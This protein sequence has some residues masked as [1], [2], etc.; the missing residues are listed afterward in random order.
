MKKSFTILSTLVLMFFFSSVVSAQPLFTEDFESGTAS[1]DWGVYRAGEENVIA[2][3]MATAPE[4][5]ANGGDYVGYVQDINGSYSG[6]AI[7]LAGA[8]SLQNYS[9]EGDVYCYVNHPGGSAYT[10]L[11]VYSDSSLGTYIKLAADFD[12]DERFR[13]YNNHLDFVTFQYTFHHGFAASDVPGGIP[14]VDGWHH[15]KVEV[16][17]INDSTTAFWCYFDGQ[18]LLGSPIY[19]T[20]EDQMDSGQFGLYSFQQDGDGIAAYFDNI[21]VNDLV[22]S[23]EDNSNSIIPN[24]IALEQNYPNPFNPETQISYKLATGGYISLAIHDLLGREIKTLVSEEQ[25]SGN[26]TVSWDGRDELGN[27]VPSGIYFYSLKAGKFVESKKMIMM[28]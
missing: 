5:L 23:V 18:M 9:I 6:A 27:K 12:A 7:I 22:T 24:E 25:P 1:P 13:L 3:T 8:T 19:D 21:V 26:Y 16:R 10:G 17:T 28:K 2:V 4:P 14:T 15:M 11:A 20:G